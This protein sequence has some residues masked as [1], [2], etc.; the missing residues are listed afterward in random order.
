MKT[1]IVGVL[2]ALLATVTIGSTARTATNPSATGS[3]QIA[4]KA[5]VH[6]FSFNAQI[7]PDGLETGQAEYRE[8]DSGLQLHINID[9]VNIS[10]NRAILGGI[11][12]QSTDERM[13]NDQ[14]F[15]SVTDNGEGMNDKPDMMSFL[16][17]DEPAACV[18]CRSKISLSE[19][20][21]IRGNI[22]IRLD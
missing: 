17:L 5:A 20:P 9:C 6:T 4:V 16:H 10:G 22:Q 8:R 15:I 21:I 18:T 3:G 12:T 2:V 1:R 7:Q 13:L 11:I 19:F 14:F